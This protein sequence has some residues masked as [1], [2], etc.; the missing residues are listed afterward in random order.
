MYFKK[1]TMSNLFY[2]F[3]YLLFN[4]KHIR[5]NNSSNNTVLLEVFDVRASVIAMSFFAKSLA[6]IHDA[7][8]ECY[9][10]NFKSFKNR[11]KFFLNKLNPFSILFVYRSFCNKDFNIPTIKKNKKNLEINKKK[12]TQIKNKQDVLDIRYKNIKIGDL[13]YDEYLRS[14]NK[15]TIDIDESSFK[16][17][18]L[19]SFELIDYWDNY[20]QNNKKNVKA[21]VSSHSVY[22]MGLVGRIGLAYNIPNYIVGWTQINRINKKNLSRY[23]DPAN[24][25]KFFKTFRRRKQQEYLALAE[26]NLR[27]RLEGKKDI[28]RNISR[29]IDPVYAK[30]K[31][32]DK[33]IINNSKLNVLIAS[34]CFNDAPHFYGNTIFLDFYEWID[35]L[36]KKSMEKKYNFYLKIHPAH[37]K[38]SK[39][40]I[41]NFLKKY[42]DLKLVPKTIGHNQLI[43]E[44]ID[45]ALTVFG[46]IAHEYPF[47]NIPVVTC[48][49]NPQQGYD[50]CYNPKTYNEYDQI[51]KNLEKY[52]IKKN[53]KKSILEF[54]FMHYL[55]DYFFFGNAKIDTKIINT[56]K[57]YKILM[58]KIK[59]NYFYIKT[60]KVF[61]KFILSKKR[62]I[63]FN[64]R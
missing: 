24:Y 47:L 21:I 17:F 14:F 30:K 29:P 40:T 3:K 45:V 48:G 16:D 11:L 56:L 54:Y 59:K 43:E 28:L 8:I 50:F 61:S 7:N 46:S 10:P 26:K 55:T 35:Y 13:I 41:I 34:H 25:H 49:D 2:Y 18:L 42:P 60:N 39:K 58:D 4:R 23:P 53:L 1:N 20:F 38:K 9:Y 36:G 44:G 31:T 57:I 6:N 63:Y 22:F 27:L 52:K 32:T 37:Y 51:I 5:F 33:F 12:T 15:S 62:R 64:D 19:N